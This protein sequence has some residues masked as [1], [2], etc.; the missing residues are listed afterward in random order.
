MP[1]NRRRLENVR[2]A[3]CALPIPTRSYHERA[4][5]ERAYQAASWLRV[6]R[7]VL[8][9]EVMALGDHPRF[10][11]TTLDHLSIPECLYWDIYSACG[12]DRSFRGRR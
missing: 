2:R 1:Q 10:V 5:H 3:G 4:Y 11:V 12:Q 7:V 6:F 8:K 9:A